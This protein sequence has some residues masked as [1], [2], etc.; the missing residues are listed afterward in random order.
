MRRRLGDRA[1]GYKLRKIDPLFRMIPHIMKD[2]SDAQVFFEDTIYLEE[3]HKFIRQLRKQGHR[4]G[5]L[6]IVVATMVRVMS[7]RPKINRFVVGKKIYARN[8]ISFSLSI[9]K[10]MNDDAE[11]TVIKFKFDP[12]ATIID[13]I[14]HVND[15]IDENKE[16]EEKNKM[17]VFVRI[18][19]K[20]PN[21]IYG[22]L[23][24]FVRM[25][26]YIG[27]LPKSIISLSPFHSSAFITDL[28]SIGIKPVYHHIYN[29]GTN[30]IFIAFGTRSKEQTLNNEK[31]IVNRKRMDLRIVADER[32]CDGYYFAQSLKMAK[33]IMSNPECLMT[34]PDKVVIDDQI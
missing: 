5:F 34:P 21:F 12:K 7:Q 22:F 13:V 18:F 3:T 14:N 20:F 27:I 33:R 1:D 15:I 16:V 23:M 26:D 31:E 17:D 11:E 2:R 32:V 4:V 10:E 25:L 9:K 6:H 19:S 8:E 24:N 30:T 28:G 29:L